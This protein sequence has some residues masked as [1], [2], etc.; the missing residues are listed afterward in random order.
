MMVAAARK[1]YRHT[2]ILPSDDKERLR[3]E[4]VLEEIYRHF[5]DQKFC[6]H[7][8][9]KE[10]LY[11]NED[12]LGRFF[13]KISGKKFTGFLLDVRISA[14][15][16]L[17]RLEPDIMVYMVSEMTGYASD[18]QYFSRIFKKSTGMTPSE[19]REKIQLE[20]RQDVKSER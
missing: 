4:R 5:Q 17:M 14:A 13:Q 10:I 15:E 3:Y 16:Q 6:L 19:Y 2:C 11:I 9:A 8:L 20:N 18:G 12:Y 1:I 7:Y